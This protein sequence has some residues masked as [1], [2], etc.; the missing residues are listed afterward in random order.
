MADISLA[1]LEFFY[2]FYEN[3]F[4]FFFFC[5]SS[6][7]TIYN[8]RDPQKISCLTAVKIQLGHCR[9]R[10]LTVNNCNC[11]LQP[12]S[13]VARPP[14]LNTASLTFYLSILSRLGL[15]WVL[16][17]ILPILSG[18]VGPVHSPVKSRYCSKRRKDNERQLA[19]LSYQLS[20]N[21]CAL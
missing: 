2:F 16:S 10:Q 19:E 6:E 17:S 21:R 12:V 3:G 20:A 11:Q 15:P 9:C 8:E 4:F 18:S 14:S 13:S 5:S 7:L 1:I